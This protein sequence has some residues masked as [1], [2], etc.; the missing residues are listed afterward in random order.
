MILKPGKTWYGSWDDGSGTA[1]I[2]V[3]F[4]LN[5]KNIGRTWSEVSWWEDQCSH[6]ANY[7][8]NGEFLLHWPD[9]SSWSCT[10]SDGDAIVLV[11]HY[12]WNKRL[13]NSALSWTLFFLFIYLFIILFIILFSWTLFLVT[14][15]THPCSFVGN[16]MENVSCW[17]FPGLFF[18]FFF[19]PSWSSLQP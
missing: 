9:A 17:F 18:F 5:Y 1:M 8:E 19:K 15:W 13:N 10:S 16:S 4:Q 11:C 6:R 12:R 2:I 14:S 7:W 3:P